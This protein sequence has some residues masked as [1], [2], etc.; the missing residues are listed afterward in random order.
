MKKLLLFIFILVFFLSAYSIFR[1]CPDGY[2]REDDRGICVSCEDP[3]I[4]HSS[5]CSRCPNRIIVPGLDKSDLLCAPIE[6]CPQG[7][8]LGNHGHCHSCS[9]KHPWPAS[10]EECAKCKDAEGNSIRMM[11]KNYGISGI[12]EGCGL[13]ECEQGK[14][15]T[16]L[17]HCASCSYENPEPAIAEACAMCKDADG[18]PTRKMYRGVYKHPTV[19]DGCGPIKCSQGKFLDDFGH[20]IPCQQEG[21]WPTSA[22][23]CDQCPNREYKEGKCSFEKQSDN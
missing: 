7:S 8:F 16:I 5:E 6:K 22:E 21:S 3:S 18:N 9:D 11:Y 1:K 2:F 14:F 17:G 10:P 15:T 23:K 13:I 20:C 19:K 4:V 12:P